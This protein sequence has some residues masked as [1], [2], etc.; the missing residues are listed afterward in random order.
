M[1]RL[2]AVL[3]AALDYLR[4]HMWQIVRF[5]VV[6]GLTF[7]LYFLLFRVLYGTIG[8]GYKAAISLA[9]IVTVCCHFLLHRSFT[10]GVSR[11]MSIHLGR[12]GAMLVLNYLTTLAVMWTVVELLRISPYWGPL[13]ST[14]VTAASSFF[15]MKHFVFVSGRARA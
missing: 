12:Y 6:G 10:F 8:F 1:N 3:S 7:A 4:E 13:A 9:Y 5:V 11:R 2:V 14:G 15:V